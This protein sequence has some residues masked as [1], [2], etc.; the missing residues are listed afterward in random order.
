MLT[1]CLLRSR[2]LNL[3]L[4]QP[5]LVEAD[6]DI[7]RVCIKL[8]ITLVFKASKKR[9]MLGEVKGGP[10]LSAQIEDLYKRL[11]LNFSEEKRTSQEL[12]RAFVGKLHAFEI[13][14]I[15]KDGYVQFIHLVS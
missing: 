14:N 1:S 9:I 4:I 5:T 7:M 8:V 2:I 6:S 10:K 15:Q 3:T 13:Q 12:M 11:D